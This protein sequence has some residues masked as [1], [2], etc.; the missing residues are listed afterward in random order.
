[1]P[2]RG[3]FRLPASR[4]VSDLIRI[5]VKECDGGTAAAVKGLLT[6][7]EEQ[8]LVDIHPHPRNSTAAGGVDLG[9]FYFSIVGAKRF[10]PRRCRCRCR[11]QLEPLADRSERL[12]MP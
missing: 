7:T 2:W 1:M 5:G 8:L 10:E 9:L 3:L 4:P 6:G 12:E 11:C